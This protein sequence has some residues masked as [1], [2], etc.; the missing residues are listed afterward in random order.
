MLQARWAGLRRGMTVSLE[1]VRW[2]N[3]NKVT[4]ALSCGELYD[5]T[6]FQSSD[7]MRSR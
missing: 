2:L 1:V 3:L 5:S 6:H 7:E 4:V